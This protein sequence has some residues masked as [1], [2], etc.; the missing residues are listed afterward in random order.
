M[1]AFQTTGPR[2]DATQRG[3]AQSVPVSGRVQIPTGFRDRIPRGFHTDFTQRA[4]SPVIFMHHEQK[5]ETHQCPWNQRLQH[6]CP[7]N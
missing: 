2:E 4:V 7:R 3:S 5:T 1:K 6:K